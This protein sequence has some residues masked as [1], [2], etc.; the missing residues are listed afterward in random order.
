[1]SSAKQTQGEIN[2]SHS[3]NQHFQ[4]GRLLGIMEA[5]GVFSRFFV[6]PE[7]HCDLY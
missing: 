7:Q 6:S 5:E 3:S 1:M 4:A 2:K